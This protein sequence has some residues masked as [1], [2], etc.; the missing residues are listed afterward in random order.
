MT[1]IA[2]HPDNPNLMLS[3]SRDKTVLVWNLTGGEDYGYVS[4]EWGLGHA[5]IRLLTRDLKL[6]CSVVLG[7]E[8]WLSQT[9]TD[10]DPTTHTP[11]PTPDH[12]PSAPSA[13]TGTSSR[14]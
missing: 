11:C 6:C 12:S 7:H 14:T 8:P 3:S 13:A 9:N 4:F 1:S 5:A 10:D 2:T